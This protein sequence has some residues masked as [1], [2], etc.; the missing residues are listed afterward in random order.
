M[1]FHPDIRTAVTRALQDRRIG[2]DP[3]PAD[4]LERLTQAQRD[5]LRRLEHFGWRVLYVRRPQGEP[6]LV[7]VSDPSGND[8]AILTEAGALDRQSNQQH[9]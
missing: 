5:G 7:V 2:N 3:V 8:I 4:L 1:L 9:R 6:P